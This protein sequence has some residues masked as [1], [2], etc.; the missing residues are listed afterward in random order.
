MVYSTR[1]V[2]PLKC[3]KCGSEIPSESKFCLSCGQAIASG[4]PETPTPTPRKN[5]GLLA[6]VAGVL[7]VALIIALALM[8]RGRG[9][10]QSPSVQVETAPVLKAPQIPDAPQPSVLQTEAKQPEEP[11]PPPA[12]VVAYLEHLKKVEQARMNLQQKEI[13]AFTRM[14]A[15]AWADPL[16]KML[17]MTDPDIPDNEID[18]SAEDLKKE[19]AGLTREWQQLSAYF[20]SVP[21][22][23]PCQEL[24][25]K[26]Y[27]A[28]RDVIVHVGKL[29]TYLANQDMN[30]MSM[31]GQSGSID[32]KLQAAD[33]ELA[34]VC[35]QF[36]IE[37]SFKVHS[38]L[39]QTP[40]LGF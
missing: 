10:T 30:V 9:V 20:L 14:L 5:S 36:N 26:Y 21:A 33:T 6:A 39:A 3:I 31:R 23:Q 13:A 32:H 15:Q 29:Q 38:D 24:A 17:S 19:M 40:V 22:P 1:E 8:A 27:D 18:S 28:L 4:R 34:K 11:K 7:I 25:G 37:K 16:K 12:D 35:T 2:D